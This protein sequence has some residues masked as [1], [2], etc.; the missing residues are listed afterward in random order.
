MPDRCAIWQEADIRACAPGVFH[1]DLRHVNRQL[2]GHD[3][4]T[5]RRLYR[6]DFFSVEVVDLCIQALQDDSVIDSCHIL[7]RSLWL[8][9]LEDDIQPAPASICSDFPL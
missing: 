6:N 7:L 3:I 4:N 8:D 2:I 5:L 1:R 9:R